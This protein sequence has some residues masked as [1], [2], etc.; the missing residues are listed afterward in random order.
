MASGTGL[1]VSPGLVRAQGAG[2][3]VALVIGNSK[4][5]W[6]ASLPN[7]RRDAPDIARCFQS[8]G[9][10][11]ELLQDAGR[12]AM[13]AA[14]E[15][16]KA[17]ASGANFAVFYFAGHGASWDKDTYLAPVD[18]DLGK[19]E[20]V[21]TLLPVGSVSTAMSRAANR[22]LIFDNCRNNPADGWRQK[23]AVNSSSKIND[24]AQLATAL[25]TQ[26]RNAL[27]LF[28][29]A[30]GRIAL[31][32]PSGE[33]SPFAAAFLRQFDNSPVDISALATAVRRDLLI[34]TEGQ[35]VAWDQS[36]YTGPFLVN[37]SA[38]M[39]S[40]KAQSTASPPSRTMEIPQ[41][42]AFAR[43]RKLVLPPG[44]VACRAPES[45][46]HARMI[47]SFMFTMKVR[48]GMVGSGWGFEPGLLTV[49]SVTDSTTAQVIY[50]IKDWDS[51]KTGVAQ[52]ALWRF[53]PAAITGNRLEFSNI[54]GDRLSFTW[55]DANSGKVDFFP[56]GETVARHSTLTGISTDFT[57]LDG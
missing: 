10:K 28:S 37:R 38:T 6:E 57:R 16:F 29:T 36:T 33:N 40:G 14:V 25:R 12:E 17:A 24:R 49:L 23:A 4:Y 42:Y 35:Q 7:V 8:Y 50:A 32:G 55:R 19:P 52:G 27:V 13:F 30:P 41:A 9:L 51:E 53:V 47:G 22:L 34:A 26:G 5:A 15:K 56:V 43:E 48:V 46:P 11:T 2:N 44:L 45:S 18:A 31:D 54:V 20:V 39:P 1:L 21:Q 3:G